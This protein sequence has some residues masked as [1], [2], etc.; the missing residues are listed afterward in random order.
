MDLGFARWREA[1]RVFGHLENIGFEKFEI[2]K[3]AKSVSPHHTRPVAREAGNKKGEPRSVHP[4]F[5]MVEAAGIEPAS[6]DTPPLA[7]HA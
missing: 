3:G 5:K 4:F 6:A 2:K 1:Q 7:L